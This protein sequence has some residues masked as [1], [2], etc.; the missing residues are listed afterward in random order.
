[1]QIRA[2]QQQRKGAAVAIASIFIE[3][4]CE[5]SGDPTLGAHQINLLLQLYLRGSIY[6][7]DM[8]KVTGLDRSANSRNLAKMG[9]GEAPAKGKVG[10]GYVETEADLRNRRMNVV[11][12]TA[13]GRAVVEEAAERAAGFVESLPS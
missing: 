3:T 4:V 12:L 13:K 5:L 1:M 11:R 10:H 2:E 6:Q 9:P 8:Q 7:V